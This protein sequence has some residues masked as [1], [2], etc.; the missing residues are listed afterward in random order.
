MESTVYMLTTLLLIEIMEST[1][2]NSIT[3]R[4]NGEHCLYVVQ[5]TLLLIE[6]MESTVYI[7]RQL[8]Y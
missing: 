3:N 8:Y 2:Y 4:N 7:F 1:V 5:T 6:I